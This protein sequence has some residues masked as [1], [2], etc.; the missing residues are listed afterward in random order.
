MWKMWKFSI[1]M[2][3]IINLIDCKA[4]DAENY[5]TTDFFLNNIE[6]LRT[7]Y[8]FKK[9][10]EHFKK[11]LKNGNAFLGIPPMDPYKSGPVN[12][13]LNSDDIKGNISINSVDI[14]ELSNYRVTRAEIEG[15]IIKMGFQWSNING[16]ITAYEIRNGSFMN[17]IQIFGFGDAV[18]TL[19]ELNFNANITLGLKNI[20]IFIKSVE[21]QISLEDFE[22]FTDGLYNDSYISKEMCAVISQMGPDFIQSY[23]TTLTTIINEKITKIVEKIIGYISVNRLNFNEILQ[24]FSFESFYPF[25]N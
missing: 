9:F 3:I 21:S 7:N 11:Y 5:L 13:I 25:R 14:S 17:F 8:L 19:N 4:V 20:K 10:L 23:Q 18:F 16:N 15:L 2:L 6:N 24:K 22:F 1:I 12:T